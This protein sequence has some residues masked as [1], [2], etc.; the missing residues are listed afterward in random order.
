MK[1]LIGLFSKTNSPS[2]AITI[3]LLAAF[4]VL[5]TKTAFVAG[6]MVVS[7]AVEVVTS[8]V[9]VVSAQG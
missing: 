9:V 8:G 5:R 4:D 1:V 6:D 7:G 2:Q 3:G